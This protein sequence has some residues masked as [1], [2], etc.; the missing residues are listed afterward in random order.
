METKFSLESL[1]KELASLRL[2]IEQV[3][4][5]SCITVLMLHHCSSFTDAVMGSVVAPV[6][7]DR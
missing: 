2:I 6:G 7:S 3:D 5:S 1:V 4:H